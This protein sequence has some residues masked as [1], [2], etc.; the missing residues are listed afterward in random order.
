MDGKENALN[1]ASGWCTNP[2]R[3][4]SNTGGLVVFGGAEG[5]GGLRAKRGR[6]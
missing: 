3:E 1:F 2:V 6:E 4:L 5:G